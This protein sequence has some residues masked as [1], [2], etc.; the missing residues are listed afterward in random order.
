VSEGAPARR[1]APTSAATDPATDPAIGALRPFDCLWCG[2]TWQPRGADDLATL[3]RLCPD[4]LGRADSNPFIRFRLHAALEARAAIAGAESSGAATAGA[5]TAGGATAGVS[6]IP[7]HED[8]LVPY[9]EARAPEYD[10]WYLRR[11]RYAH[12]PVQDLAWQMELD[13]ATTWLDRLP[14]RG[15]I[16]ELAAG[17][18]WWTALLATKGELHAYDAAPAPLD[19]ARARLV[20]HGLRAHLHVRDA[21]A[22]PDRPVDSLFAGFWLSHVPRARLAMFLA[23]ALRWLRP[24]GTLALVDSLDDPASG[25]RER[26]EAPAPDL[27][28]RRLAD[29]RT[30][31]IPKVFYQPDDVAAVM[32]SLGFGH[33]ETTRTGRFFFLVSGQAGPLE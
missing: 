21:W 25:T 1:A 18:G 20:A 17:T 2:R 4:C 5:A 28:L 3:A 23:L 11:G 9:Y 15:E 30:F 13:R 6:A 22:P 14:L 10:D 19:L 31:T 29:G 32:R 7:T 26:A 12:G 33:V 16:V 27:A 24:G 8:E